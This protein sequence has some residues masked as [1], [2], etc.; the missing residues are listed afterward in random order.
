MTI[1]RMSLRFN[2][3]NENDNR[4][5]KHIQ[6][7]QESKNRAVIDMTNAHFDEENSIQ[8]VIRQTIEE[9]LKGVEI[10]PQNSDTLHEEITDEE[11]SFLDVMDDF[12][13][14]EWH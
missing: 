13:G 11:S 14:A 8:E 9:C 10:K 4:A 7:L 6:S 3:E 5:W 1:K 12:L 2:L